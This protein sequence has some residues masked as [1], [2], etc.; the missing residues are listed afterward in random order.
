MGEEASI[1]SVSLFKFQIKIF[2]G[3]LIP[4]EIFKLKNCAKATS[5]EDMNG[6]CKSNRNVEVQS[7]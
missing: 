1:L 5:Y 7:I 3:I 2:S 6:N 4:Q